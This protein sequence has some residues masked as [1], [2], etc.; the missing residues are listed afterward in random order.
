VDKR[1]AVNHKI[2]SRNVNNIKLRD[3]IE[4]AGAA[5]V[6]IGLVF[7]GLELRQNTAAMEAATLQNQTDASTE[8][9]LLIASDPEL[10]RIWRDSSD[11][12]VEMNELDTVRFFLVSRARW[13][14]MQN[15]YLQWQRGTLNDED[16][17][18]YDGIIC[19]AGTTGPVRFSRS[20]GGHRVALSPKFVEYV[21]K[22]WSKL[23]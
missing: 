13:L 11:G 17:A 22:C 23:D 6:L 4:L 21:E 12:T 8:F 9:L 10:T 5:A 3:F 19:T 2:V 20:W 18:F 14:R 16:W 15:A 1:P 7:V